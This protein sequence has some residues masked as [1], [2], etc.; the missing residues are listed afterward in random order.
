MEFKNITLLFSISIISIFT[1]NAQENL[2]ESFKDTIT[3]NEENT[4]K[5]IAFGSFIEASI[6][7]NNPDNYN[8]KFNKESFF[9]NVFN[10]YPEIN[11]E[12]EFVKG[13]T[14]GLK[15]SLDSF[16][17]RIITEVENGSYYDFINYSYD[18]E[19]QTYYLL[20]RLYSLETGMNYHNYRIQKNKNKIEFSDIYVYVTGEFLADTIGRLLR[21]SIPEIEKED[22]GKQY[23]IDKD[24]KTLF[25]AIMYNKSGL[26]DKAYEAMEKLESGLSKEKFVLILKTLMA[27]QIDETKYLKSL[28]D[29]ISTFPEDPTLA[30]NRIDYHIFREEYFEAIQ[31][32]NQLQNETEDDFLNFIK[33]TVAFQDGNYDLAFNMFSFI[34]EDYPGFFD[35]QV[36][37]LN[38]L[39]MMENYADAIIYLDTLLAEGYD[40]SSLIVYL[41]EDDESGENILELFIQTEDFKA[42]KTKKD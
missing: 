33:G 38:V 16:P 6:H 20:F 9:E 10:Y 27:S 37:Y 32:I 25:N 7:E 40:K 41:E 15:K 18:Y 22:D 3:Y 26:F 21:Y 2:K 30:L 23:Q 28:E 8:S 11:R 19:S 12:D 31:V 14:N 1:S 29:L 24:S 36:G 17:T 13:F 5:V 4:E 42:W 34:I 35:G 39:V